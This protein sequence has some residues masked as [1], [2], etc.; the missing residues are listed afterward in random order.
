MH[1]CGSRQ[2]E[3]DRL[4]AVPP[5]QCHLV[6]GGQLD[7]C[8][9]NGVVFTAVQW[10]RHRGELDRVAAVTLPAVGAADD[11]PPVAGDADADLVEV[12]FVEERPENVIPGAHHREREPD[13]GHQRVVDV[14]QAVALRRVRYD[15][16]RAQVDEGVHLLPELKRPVEVERLVE[17]GA[18]AV[19]APHVLPVGH[20]AVAGAGQVGVVRVQVVEHVHQ[21]SKQDKA[22]I[23]DIS[24]EL[25]RVEEANETHRKYLEDAAF[26][27]PGDR[28]TGGAV[29]GFQGLDEE[30]RRRLAIRRHTALLCRLQASTVASWPLQ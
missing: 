26:A 29:V 6:A 2:A 14:V 21:L 1:A 30:V 4:K 17:A 27:A 9:G 7:H 10:V 12:V 24:A 28:F 11:R 8:L 13:P 15:P 20:P 22:V 16:T 5:S 18:S 19:G 25:A 3:E 23:I